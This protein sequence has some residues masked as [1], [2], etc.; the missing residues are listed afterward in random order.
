MKVF[1]AVAGMTRQ[2]LHKGNKQASYR[3][4][5]HQ[6]FFEQADE[7]RKAHPGVG[8]RKMARQLRQPGWGRDKLER[9]LLDK[10][11]RVIYQRRFVKTTQRQLLFHYPNLMEAKRVDGIN[12]VVQT[13][14]TYYRVKDRFYYLTFL[15]DVYSR[16]IVGYCVSR[17]LHAIANLKALKMLLTT[18]RNDNLTELIHHSDKGAQ[19]IYRPYLKLLAEN[20]IRISMCDAPWENAYAER[21]NRTIKQEYLDGWQ[22]NN[23]QQLQRSV[24]RAV[25][26]YN[27]KRSHQSLNWNTPVNFERQQR[28]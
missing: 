15:K 3:H 26:H 18:R 27:E 24:K 21:L 4:L 14:I 22:I 23:F 1:Y 9:L 5:Q 6:K 2:A 19:F 16:R 12:Q 10:G 17:T 8:C 13:D 20:N 28:Q 11:Y 7:I 25:A